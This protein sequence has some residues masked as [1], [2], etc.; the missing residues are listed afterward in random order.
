MK[1]KM[2]GLTVIMI[3]LGII[4][5]AQA[6]LTVIGTATYDDGTGAQE[7][8]LIWDDDNNGNSVVWLDYMNDNT[9]W[10][11]QMGWA[12]GL[13]EQLIYNIDPIYTVN[14]I[15][16]DWRLPATVDGPL[17]HGC[18]GTTTAGYNITTS[19]MGH[20]YYIELGN[21]GYNST[22]DCSTEQPGW[23]LQNTDPFQNLHP[24]WYWSDTDYGA[25]LDYAWSFSFSPFGPGSQYAH[26]KGS[27]GEIS[28]GY[29]LAI[30][31]GQVVVNDSIPTLSEWGQIL[32]VVILGLSAFYINRKRQLLA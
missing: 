32:L 27:T 23:G 4:G 22:T 14:W 17:V 13:D 19:E 16:D 21:L 24:A 25:D 11:P 6:T 10:T 5:M 28:G 2:I 26:H 18:D 31:T 12:A 3:L 9:I 20:L 30:R 8:N 7:C 1:K 15:D 29:G